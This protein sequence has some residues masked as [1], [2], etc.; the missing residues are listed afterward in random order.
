[1]ENNLAVTA[2]TS[3]ASISKVEVRDT[4]GQDCFSDTVGFIQ[5]S[6]LLG[7][8]CLQTKRKNVNYR[9]LVLRYKQSY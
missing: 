2:H 5:G 7:R 3:K 4:W 1:M 9:N 8:P 6:V